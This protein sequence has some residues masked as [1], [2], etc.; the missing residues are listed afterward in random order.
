MKNFDLKKVSLLLLFLSFFTLSFS[1]TAQIE[2]RWRFES[3]KNQEGK[4]LSNV[5][6]KDSLVFKNN[7][8]EYALASKDLHAKGDY[9][10]DGNR[11]IFHYSQP[12]DTTRIYQYS[13]KNKM[14]NLQEG[15]TTFRFASIKTPISILEENRGIF[16]KI[17]KGIL[18]I[19]MIV[20]FAF[21]LSRDRKS[22]DWALVG[23][24]IVLQ[25]IIAFL[26]LKVGFVAHVFDTVSKFF[27]EVINFT[28]AGVGFLFNSWVD[29]QLDNGLVNF[30]VKVLPTIIFFS[31]LTSLLYYMG[32]LQKIVYLL[33]WAMKKTLGLSGAE[34][35]SAAGNIFLGQ[36]ESPFLVKPFIAGMTKSEIMSLMTGGMATLAGGVLAA[37]IGFLGGTDLE[38]QVFFAKHLL[39]ASVMS[40]PAAIVAAKIIVPETEEFDKELKVSQEKIG[41]N[42]L[43]A[44]SN[45]TTDGVKLAVNVGAMLLVFT[46]LIA[47]GNYLLG[48]IIGAKTGLNEVIA[49]NTQYNV[50]SFQFL[51]GY[52]GA[53]IAW[54]VGVPSEDIVMVGQLLG[55]KT[56]LNE[57]YAYKTL[58]EMK[59][60]GVFTYE[61]SIIIATYILCGFSNIASIGIQ[62]GGISVLAPNQK[63]TL[64]KLGVYALIGGTFACLFTAAIIG[65]II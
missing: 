6:L 4:S 64:S 18:G 56:I 1:A 3:I 54:M 12:N 63:T 25:I 65:M 40:A 46:A 62:I 16:S 35:L 15:N 20:F 23:K 33:A 31:A 32:I 19:L 9:H 48:D 24:G 52:I 7:F 45:G 43:E 26:V 60:A 39:A 61:R 51:V 34:S 21:L 36:T 57:F 22:I 27:V 53:P 41:S 50:F 2:G 13:I 30:A 11:L 14:L 47:M 59:D 42:A 8:F 37:Y 5:S 38:M 10:I 49:T 55:E 17:G 58:G 44:I 29:G 28:N